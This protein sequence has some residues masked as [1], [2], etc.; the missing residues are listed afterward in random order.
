MNLALPLGPRREWLRGGLW[1][2]LFQL[3]VEKHGGVPNFCS[4]QHP[5]CWSKK[6]IQ[7]RKNLN[8]SATYK[9]KTIYNHKRVQNDQTSTANENRSKA[10]GDIPPKVKNSAT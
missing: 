8:L 3:Q 9:V 7:M 4:N 2:A 10:E 1:K 6:G 5:F